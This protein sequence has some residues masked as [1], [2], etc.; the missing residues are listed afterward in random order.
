MGCGM[1]K[2]DSVPP[3]QAA[4]QGERTG[5]AVTA[6]AAGRHALR[7]ARRGPLQGGTVDIL[8]LL[9]QD[10]REV[11]AMFG[12]Y[13][14]GDHAVVA[15][16]M[17][18]LQLHTQLE[19]EVLYPEIETAVPGGGEMV[20]HAKDEHRRVDSVL[21]QLSQ[22]PDDE[23]AAQEL[24]TL[25]SGHVEEEE[26]EVFPAVRDTVDPARLEALGGKAEDMKRGAS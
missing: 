5:S 20:S 2:M 6:P 19:E 25:V 16:L 22:F 1:G 21:M 17:S 18:A 4:D 9:E 13:H 11:E 12:R 3:P 8:A 7:P 15:E 24:E 10:H 23:H 14:D 26:S